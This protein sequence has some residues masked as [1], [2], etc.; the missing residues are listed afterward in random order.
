MGKRIE[1]VDIGKYICIMFVM[2]S[3]LESGTKVLRTFYSPFFLTVFFFLAGYVYKQPSAFKELFIKKTK[4]LFV[5]WL[6]LSNI[7]IGMSAVISLKSNHNLW[8]DLFWNA[9]QIGTLGAV[10]WFVPALYVAF[11]PFYFIL[12]IDKREKVIA[13]SLLLS[14]CSN[15]YN[16]LMPKDILPWGSAA[17]PWHLEFIFVAIFWMVLG[18]YYRNAYEK[19]LKKFENMTVFVV[20]ALIYI[21]LV[22]ST[23]ELRNEGLI[24]M[25]SYVKSSI[26]IFMVIL[27]CKKLK[28]TRYISYVGAN[29]IIFFAFH[30]KLY[31]VLEH[32]L[33]SKASGFYSVCLNNV[34]YSSLF[35]IVLTFIMSIILI[36]PAY[37]INRWF[38]WVVGKSRKTQEKA[39]LPVTEYN[40]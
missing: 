13:L 8:N 3:H 24:L 21:I 22:Y 32:I 16:M 10:M 4:G 35:A 40:R 29:T 25:L 23:S 26:G 38:P 1:W 20:V 30:G 34:I 9:L 11:M 15:I 31:A 12:K 19:S 6:I 5:P 36:V 18:Y 17:L 33:R 37:C 39:V 7:L 2:L 14:V 28:A 27:L